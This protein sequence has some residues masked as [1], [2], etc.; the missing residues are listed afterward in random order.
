MFALPRTGRLGVNVQ[1]ARAALPVLLRRGFGGCA[2]FSSTSNVRLPTAAERGTRS[3]RGFTLLELLIVVGIIGLLLVL[4][5]PAFTTIK[6]GTD[7][8][9]AAYT[10]KGMLD[11]ARTYAKANNT[12]TWVGFYEEDATATTPTNNTPAYPG[13]GRVLLTIV[14]SKDG[15]KIYEDT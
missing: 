9:S 15:T 3:V 5:A 14:A 10:I 12:Y 11:T 7:V 4:I 2:G 8:T 1:L 13:K 6:G